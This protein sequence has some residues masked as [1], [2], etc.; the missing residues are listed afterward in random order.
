MHKCADLLQSVAS[1]RLTLL[2]KDFSLEHYSFS[3]FIRS[4]QLHSM[5]LGSTSDENQILNLWISLESLIPNETRSEDVSN[6]EHIIGSLIPFLNIGYVEGLVNNLVKDL[7]RWDNKTV[8]LALK[9][10]SGRKLSERLAKALVLPEYSHNIASIESNLGDFHLLQDRVNHFK[11]LLSSPAKIVS[12]LDAHKL[13][14]AW[15]LR[16]IYRVRNIIVHS[17]KTP[18]YTKSLIE[19]THGY[20]DTVLSSLVRLA[21]KPKKIHSVSQG[22]KYVELQYLAYYKSLSEKDLCFDSNNIDTLLFSRL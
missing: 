16:R 19:H 6:I 22:F 21:S 4:V 18:P 2:L 17:G 1:N 5:A 15:Q 8:R 3:K 14:L 7:L 13:R 12:A 11:Q 9:H 20:L 10:I